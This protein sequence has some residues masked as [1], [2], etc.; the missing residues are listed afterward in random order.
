MCANSKIDAATQE[1]LDLMTFAKHRGYAGS[2]DN[3]DTV[4]AALSDVAAEAPAAAV[5]LLSRSDY[6]THAAN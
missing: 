3:V 6:W 4:L 2:L 1:F 5:K